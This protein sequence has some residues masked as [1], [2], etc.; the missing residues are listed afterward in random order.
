MQISKT[1]SIN[2]RREA[3]T[4][5]ALVIFALAMLAE[6]LTYPLTASQGG[7]ENVWYVSPALFPLV[8]GSC[9]LLLASIQLL[10]LYKTA[11]S[12]QQS[13]FS[14][15]SA[16]SRKFSQQSIDK[17]LL[18]LMLAG[19]VY[20]LIPNSDFVIAT[21]LFQLTI[22][23][24][25]YLADAK[26]LNEQVLLVFCFVAA[27]LFLLNLFVAF[28]SDSNR[29]YMGDLISFPALGFVLYKTERYLT[30][31]QLHKQIRILLFACVL[32]PIIVVLI[33]KYLLLVPMPSESSVLLL[34]DYFY[35]QVLGF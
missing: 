19:Y 6:S 5:L 7:L 32:L 33:F 10:K 35:Y 1:D 14:L 15:A 2:Y 18:V 21:I 31:N 3:F 16:P 11:K 8:V 13:L 4:S 34:T 9:I 12:Q 26:K 28:E 24:R 27:L 25:F 22:T 17:F 23:C 30:A 29:L 20:G